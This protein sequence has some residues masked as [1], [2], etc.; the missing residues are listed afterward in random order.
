L[1]KAK[2]NKNDGIH[3][4]RHSFATHLLENGTDISFIQQ[5]LGHNGIE[6]TM[7]YAKIAQ[8]GLKKIKV[9]WIICINV[10]LLCR[11]FQAKK[12]VEVS[13]KRKMAIVVRKNDVAGKV[14][15]SEVLCKV[16]TN[17]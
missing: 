14:R 12:M 11:K 15:M 8:K 3:S 10:L 7:K 5:L 17:R 9:R 6:T 4:L 16:L 1:E 2:I 13:K